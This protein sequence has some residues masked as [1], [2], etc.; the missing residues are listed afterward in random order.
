MRVIR[1]LVQ[2]LCCGDQLEEAPAVC[3]TETCSKPVTR[4]IWCGWHYQLWLIDGKPR[5]E[6]IERAHHLRRFLSQC[7]VGSSPFRD[8]GVCIEWTGILTQGY[9]RF[10][11]GRK[12]PNAHRWSY[13]YFVG[14]IP[15]GLQLDHL[16]RNRRCVNPDHLEPVT[17]LEN[18][19]RGINSNRVKTHCKRGHPFDERNTY[20]DGQGYRRCHECR[21]LQQ[22]NSVRKAS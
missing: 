13:E 7:S 4:R 20:R 1:A 22:S 17:P 9:G 19:R 14:P 8:L 18:T 16:C 6:E 10:T 3:A 15:P 2:S 5:F 21:R 11:V 12:M